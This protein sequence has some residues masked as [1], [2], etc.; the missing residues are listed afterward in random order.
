MTLPPVVTTSSKRPSPIGAKTVARVSEMPNSG[1]MIGS[2]PADFGSAA[3]RSR[4]QTGL[5]Q[6]VRRGHT[7]SRPDR[8][9]S[10]RSRPTRSA[11]GGATKAERSVSSVPARLDRPLA[12]LRRRTRLSAIVATMLV[13]VGGYGVANAAN[14]PQEHVRHYVVQPGDTLWGIARAQK[15]SGDIRQL[16]S[17]LADANGG[18]NIAVGDVI[19][20]AIR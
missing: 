3:L 2:D 19:D 1:L 13:M 7:A 5:L 15:P 8:S 10:D 17:E 9:R 16:V 12:P 11:L 6:S 4:S 18:S 20:I 14:N